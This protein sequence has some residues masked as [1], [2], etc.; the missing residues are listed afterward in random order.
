MSILLVDIGNT[1]VKWASLAGGRLGRQKAAA[2]EGWGGERIARLV[3]GKPPRTRARRAAHAAGDEAG[4]S[5]RIQ[6]IVVVS[7][8]G[9][10]IDRAFAAE[11]RRRFG[12][13]PEFFKSQRR[14][15]EVTTLYAEPWRLG[16]DRLAGV[17]GAFHLAK[18]RPV[19]VVSVG[20]AMTLD[21]VDERG[22]H[23]GGAIVPAPD[24]MLGSLLTRTHGIR[25]RARGGSG[26]GGLF[27]RSTRAAIAEGARYAAAAV[28]DRAV[29]EARA[30]LGRPPL[31]LLTGGAAPV[32]RKLLRSRHRHVPDLVLQGLAVIASAPR[33]R[34]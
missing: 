9:A 8:A 11:S 3:I 16:A 21:F 25:R 27:A 24:L 19:C 1:R 28:A 14:A 13:V 17:I 30:V 15:G 29:M 2:H 10:R 7:V 31:M 34:P 20:T 22:R 23:R 32:I 26:G 33:A 4:D 12:I 6:R 18:H 5:K